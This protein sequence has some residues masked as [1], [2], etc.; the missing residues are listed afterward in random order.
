MS[1]MNLV[2]ARPAVV[3]GWRRAGVRVEGEHHSSTNLVHARPAVAEAL[4]VGLREMGKG[5]RAQ[6]QQEGS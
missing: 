2:N 3:E 5:K 4:R 6:E 1:S